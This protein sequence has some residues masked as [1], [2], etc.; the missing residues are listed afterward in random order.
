MNESR[1]DIRVGGLIAF[2]G[3]FLFAL[4]VPMTKWALESFN[5]YFTA[6]GRACIAGVIALF[7]I[8]VRRE[9][10]LRKELRRP[11]F[12]TALGAVFG[13]PIL[14]ALA[15]ERT[16]SAHVSVIA[17]IMPLV[18]AV[19]AVL[20]R[21]QHVPAQFWFAAILGT[22]GLIIF[23]ITRSGFGQSDPIADVLIIGAVFF[24]SYCYV[25]GA[26]LAREI[27]GWLVSSWIVLVTLPINIVASIALWI[28]THQNYTITAHGIIGLLYIGMF[29]MYFG[30]WFWYHGLARAGT[31]RGSQIQ[32]LQ[33][34][35]T[36]AWSALL[37]GESVTMVEIVAALFVIFCVAW[38]QITSYRS[39]TV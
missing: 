16:T 12:F 9:K 35:L 36:L 10:F 22:V 33:A 17:A 23:S 34:L 8:G 27:P 20:R 30:F 19:L 7:I 38:A 3:I 28:F 6:T 21:H 37:L 24:S 29:S 14:I 18:T 4:S 31:V 32:Q 25:E 15:L 1:R 2:I 13:W 26:I 39:A 5:P 11:L